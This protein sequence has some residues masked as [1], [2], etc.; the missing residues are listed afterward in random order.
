MEQFAYSYQNLQNQAFD[1]LSNE[2]E[3]FGGLRT[4]GGSLFEKGKICF[5]ELRGWLNR[6]EEMFLPLRA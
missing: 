3:D 4:I 2:Y 1:I 6:V 5:K